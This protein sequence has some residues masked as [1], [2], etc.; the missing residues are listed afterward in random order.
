M[1][2]KNRDKIV[3]DKAGG[4][5]GGRK[6]NRSGR[7]GKINGGESSRVDSSENDHIKD[8]SV[9]ALDLL[10]TPFLCDSLKPH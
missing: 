10:H 3:R 2:A 7:Q 6:K 5:E 8:G 4:V 9:N 1:R